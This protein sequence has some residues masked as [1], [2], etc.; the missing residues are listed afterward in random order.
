MSSAFAIALI[1]NPAAL[2]ST[3]SSRCRSTQRPDL[4]GDVPHGGEQFLGLGARARPRMTN[5]G[6]GKRT[7]LVRV[8]AFRPAV[9]RQ[10]LGRLAS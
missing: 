1:S 4:G 6:P 3:S 8:P 2:P 9:V 10:G 5:A 7:D